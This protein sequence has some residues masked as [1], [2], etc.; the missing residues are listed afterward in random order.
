MREK[1][2]VGSPRRTTIKRWGGILGGIVIVGLILLAW[3]VRSIMHRSLPLLNGEVH[4]TDLEARVTVE[5]DALGIPSIKAQNR[6]DVAQALGFLHAQDRYFQM[7]LFRR[8]AAG[9]LSELFGPMALE[10]D[11]GIRRFRLRAHARATLDE[12]DPGLRVILDAYVRGVNQGLHALGGVPF[13][14]SLLR[15]KPGDWTSEDSILTIFSMVL[16]LQ[17]PLGSQEVAL[18]VMRDTLPEALYSFLSQTGTSWDAPIQGDMMPPVSLPGADIFNLQSKASETSLPSAEEQPQPGSN[19]WAV[20]GHLTAHGSGMLANDMHL[21]L[22]VPNTWYR[23]DLQWPGSDGKPLRVTGVTLAGVPS[24]VVGSNGHVAWGFTNSQGDW[25]DIIIIKPD[26]QDEQGYL[27]PEGPR[28]FTFFE[29]Q[30]SVKGEAPVIIE[31]KWTHWGPVIGTYH[32]GD[33]LAVKWV[34]LQP[35][36]INLDLGRLEHA[37]TLQEAFDIANGCGIPAQNFCCVDRDGHAGWTIAGRI[38]RRVGCDGR[39]SSDWSDGSCRWD[40]WLPLE[41]YPRIID[42]DHGRIWTAN[43]RVVSDEMLRIVGFGG[44][45]LGARAMQIRDRLFEKDRFHERDFL[46]IQLD[47]EARFLSR[48]QVLL[49]DLLTHDPHAPPI[50]IEALKWVRQWGGHASVDSVGYRLVRA[51]R[52]QAR[53][54]LLS[55]LTVPCQEADPDFDIREIPQYERPL[56]AIISSRPP[57]AL[58]PSFESWNTYLL[59]LADRAIESV[60]Q[61]RKT[62]KDATWGERNTTAIQHPLSSGVPFLARWLDMEARPLPGDSY[63][64]RVQSPDFGASERMVVC[65]G[66][67][68]EG[69]FHMPCGQSGHPLSPFYRAGHQAWAEGRPT[70]FLPGPPQHTL[71]MKPP[72]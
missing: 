19:N 32:T 64:P 27:S 56:W 70:P 23:A 68:D 14:Y 17:D 34:A 55:A 4:L 25:A 69:L 43:A 28:A 22:R 44:Y 3:Q 11:K 12:L 61:N 35:G 60:K 13:E 29:E 59:D 36:G 51:F 9:E 50:R 15:V 38:P 24:I 20:S 71:Q 63:L 47:D 52:D 65:P 6:R 42:P 1:G 26:P 49:D 41:D 53:K 72:D 5:R 2:S 31:A 40:G 30:I 58:P 45:A 37:K 18:G 48:W 66:H 46:E 62:L 39:L 57:H 33:P 67:E 16:E 21:G 8:S 7:D 10:Y 54:G